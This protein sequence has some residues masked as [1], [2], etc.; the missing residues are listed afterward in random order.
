MVNNGW[1]HSH[2]KYDQFSRLVVGNLISFQADENEQLHCNN[3]QT[4]LTNLEEYEI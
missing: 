1:S 4:I 3:G 2:L